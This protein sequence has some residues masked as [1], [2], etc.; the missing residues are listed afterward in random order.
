MRRPP[1]AELALFA[2]TAAWGLSFVV[3]PQALASSTVMTSIALRA[4]VGLAF[5]LAVNPAALAAT[6]L[7]WRAGLLGGLLL[8]GGY[9]LQTAGLIEAASG[10]SGFLTA[11]YICLVPAFEALVYRRAP[12]GRDLLALAVATAGI[13]LMVLRA[14]LTMSLGEGLVAVAAFCWAAHIVVVGRVA[15][16]VDPIR[17]AAVQ[18]L[19]LAAVGAAGALGRGD[20]S[21]RWT[22]RFVAEL[23]FLG[24]VTNGIGFFVQAW[25]QRRV[26]PTRTAILFAGEPVFASI[27]GAWLVGETFGV[28][29]IVGAAIVMAA[30][31]LTIA[32]VKNDG[33]AASA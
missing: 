30:V 24:I 7:E 31:A 4:G 9:V 17:L 22:G 6:L 16:R 23:A 21:P 33:P 18:M 5:L 12:P 15:A 8:A 28:R 20:P 32:R 11:F 19:V 1:A 13:A 3:V 26:P 10:K 29:D 2:M 27:F 25:G 14:D